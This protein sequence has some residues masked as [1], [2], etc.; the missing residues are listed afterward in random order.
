[1]NDDA[2]RYDRM[3]ETALRGVVREALAQVAERGL[4][5]NHHFYITFRTDHPGV[6]LADALR[7]RFPAE[8]TIVLQHQF[9]GL[10][11]EHEAFE[12]TLS[13]SDKPERLVIP[14]AAVTSFADPSVRFGLQ[15]ESAEDGVGPEEPG[16][17]P[18]AGEGGKAKPAGTA[19]APLSLKTGSLETGSLETGS[20]E[21]GP[22]QT[23]SLETGSLETGQEG[24]ETKPAATK[25]AEKTHEEQGPK[26]AAGPGSG[27][28]KA[29]GE[30]KP[31]K[32]EPAE[33]VSLD[34]FRKK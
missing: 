23:G 21:T 20:L 7:E 10:K 28:D 11:V 22:L 24:R 3:V 30:A 5:G 8:M 19:L 25:P 16:T 1:M 32:A 13:F 12:V 17:A 14:F 33:V 15:F 26:P 9:W 31:G 4:P 29:A 27:R 6:T 18:H 2:L 34:A